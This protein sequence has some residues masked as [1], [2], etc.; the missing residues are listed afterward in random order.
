MNYLFACKTQPCA[1][2]NKSAHCPSFC[3]S[4]VNLCLCVCVL[5]D[6][7]VTTESHDIYN[8]YVYKWWYTH[9]PAN[10]PFTL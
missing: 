10:C 8:E 3:H 1:N 9:P 4:W 6:L 5:D 2:F 7:L